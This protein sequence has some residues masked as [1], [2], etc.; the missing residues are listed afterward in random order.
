MVF[1]GDLA[2]ALSIIALGMGYGV[3]VIS[4]I[5]M[6]GTLELLGRVIGYLSITVAAL[7]LICVTYFSTKY[8]LDGVYDSSQL[9]SSGQVHMGVSNN[10]RMNKMKECSMPG[11]SSDN[12]K[13]SISCC[14]S[15][16]A[17][18]GKANCEP[19]TKTCPHKNQQNTPQTDQ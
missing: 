16:G 8:W 2:I 4:K 10:H 17:M 18:Q 13:T 19:Q 9:I 12:S 5:Y 11:M 7:L 6:S 14:Q 15:K 3:L 1:Q